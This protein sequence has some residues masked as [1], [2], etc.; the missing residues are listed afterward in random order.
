[1]NSHFLAMYL[2]HSAETWEK[3]TA[4]SYWQSPTT[5]EKNYQF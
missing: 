5:W 3:Q 4:I 1:M 2:A